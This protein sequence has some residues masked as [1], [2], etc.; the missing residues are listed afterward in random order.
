MKR[1]LFPSI[2]AEF[3]AQSFSAASWS[4]GGS[5]P[6]GRRGDTTGIGIGIGESPFL[7]PIT[8][9]LLLSF[10]KIREEKRE[11]RAHRIPRKKY[12]P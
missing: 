7:R 9:L 1:Q 11:E 6:K 10:R 4:E 3:N 12:P 5:G 8:P 2:I